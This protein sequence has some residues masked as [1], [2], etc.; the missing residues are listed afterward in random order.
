VGATGVEV[1]E[2]GGEVGELRAGGGG[3]GETHENNRKPLWWV[4]AAEAIGI[5][6]SC[7]CR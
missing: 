5:L 4:V 3:R 6:S 2:G 1:G 7:G